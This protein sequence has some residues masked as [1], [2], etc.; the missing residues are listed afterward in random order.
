MFRLC[1]LLRSKRVSCIGLTGPEIEMIEVMVDLTKEAGGNSMNLDVVAKITKVLIENMNLQVGEIEAPR[2]LVLDH[3]LPLLNRMDLYPRIRGIRIE[4]IE[5]RGLDQ[6][7]P[8][9]TGDAE[10]IGKTPGDD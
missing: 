7:H 3:A 10:E 9:I 8:R 2:A 4:M 5:G 6:I 1:L